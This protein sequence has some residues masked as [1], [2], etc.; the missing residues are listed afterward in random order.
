MGK[1]KFKRGDSIA[2]AVVRDGAI[3]RADKLQNNIIRF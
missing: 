1:K 3:I 2:A